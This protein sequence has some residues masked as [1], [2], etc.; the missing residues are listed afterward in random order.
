MLSRPKIE[1]SPTEAAIV[2]A[3]PGAMPL[4]ASSGTIVTTAGTTTIAKQNPAMVSVT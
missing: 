4:A 3:R 1:A 2:A